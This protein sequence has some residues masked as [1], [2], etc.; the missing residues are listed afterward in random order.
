MVE[1]RFELDLPGQSPQ[2]EPLHALWY[3]PREISTVGH[4]K[5][6]HIHIQMLTITM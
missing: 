3:K 2:A 5:Y 1:Q 6:L 4:V